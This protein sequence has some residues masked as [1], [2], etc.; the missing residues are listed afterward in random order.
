MSV[1]TT[2]GSRHRATTL[3]RNGAARVVFFAGWA[4]V[5]WDNPRNSRGI[6]LLFRHGVGALHVESYRHAVLPL[7][8]PSQSFLE[9]G[10][11]PFDIR[12]ALVIA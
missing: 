9:S 8:H 7:V 6:A 10:G 2:L 1:H 4:Q 5:A 11:S 12:R 3:V